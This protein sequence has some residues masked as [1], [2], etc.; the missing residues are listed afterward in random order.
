MFPESHAFVLLLDA[1][2]IPAQLLDWAARPVHETAALHRLI[3]ADGESGRVRD[4]IFDVGRQAGR[5]RRA[6]HGDLRTR[7][8]CYRVIGSPVAASLTGEDA[9]LVSVQRVDPITLADAELRTRFRLTPRELQVARLLARGLS[10]EEIAATL[11]RSRF[12]VRRHTERVLEKL[13][14]QR[15]GQVGSR[16]MGI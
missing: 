9:I 3:Q 5:A 6:I 16:L 12:T 8:E 7:T 14:I 13:A 10:N 11:Q 2:S 15:R 4:A 1:M